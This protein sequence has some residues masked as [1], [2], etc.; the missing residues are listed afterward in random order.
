MKTTL[1]AAGGLLAAVLILPLISGTAYG[2]MSDRPIRLVVPYPPGGTADIL[3]RTLAE[4]LSKAIAKHIIVENKPGAAGAIGAAHVSRADPDGQTLLF[5]NVG[6]SAIAPA[7][8]KSR[9]YDP[10]KDFAAVALVARTPLLLV[11]HPE[12]G[13]KSLTALIETAKS[14]PGRIEY[15]SAGIG[16]FGH[17]ATELFS[18]AADVKLLH[19]PYQGQAPSVTAVVAGEVR[20]A[21]TSPS[22]TMFEMIEAGRLN[23]LGVSSMEQSPVAPDAT[24]IARRVPGFEAQFWFGVVAPAKTS[25][26]TVKELNEGV[27][28]ALS[29]PKVASQIE[30]LGAEVALATPG[31][32]QKL[33]VDEAERWDGV[34]RKAS[35]QAAN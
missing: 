3:A 19:V 35:L 23:L 2:Q 16:S 17:L 5:T 8:S 21:L 13:P 1:L 11:A 4:P 7:M 18:H 22:K 30:A 32:F 34:V 29:D 9:P 31:E 10:A 28:K 12:K 27:R 33:L 25:E 15:S 20:M 14:E 24:P 26:T 6:P